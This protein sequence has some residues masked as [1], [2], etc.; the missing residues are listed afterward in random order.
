M[1]MVVFYLLAPS[2]A[3]GDSPGSHTDFLLLLL[4]RRSFYAPIIT[5]SIAI[6]PFCAILP[7]EIPII[8]SDKLWRDVFS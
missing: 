4:H 2:A 1:L 7:L 5:L 8:F 3:C 6:S